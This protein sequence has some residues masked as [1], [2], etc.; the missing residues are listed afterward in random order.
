MEWPEE[1]TFDRITE[2]VDDLHSRATKGLFPILDVS[3]SST[4]ALGKSFS[5][6]RITTP[7][8]I[9][10]KD[11]LVA[12]QELMPIGSDIL[13]AYEYLRYLSKHQLNELRNFRSFTDIY[14]NPKKGIISTAEIC[15]I[16]QLL[17]MQ[18]KI[19]YLNNWEIFS[20]W[21][22][23]QLSYARQLWFK[24]DCNNYNTEDTL[25]KPDKLLESFSDYSEAIHF[26]L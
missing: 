8:N 24:V 22:F 6:S 13:Y 23:F 10:M 1:F 19:C 15:V 4:C 11:H 14:S 12:M 9:K 20:Y 5:N 17:A 3:A 16:Y 7:D 18:N 2:L 26:G 21:C 25:S